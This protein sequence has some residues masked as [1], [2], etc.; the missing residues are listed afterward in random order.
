MT[1]VKINKTE[2]FVGVG[3]LVVYLGL[4]IAFLSSDSLVARMLMGLGI[5][6]TLCRSF[7]GFAGSVNRAYGTG[8]TKLMRSMAIMFLI[9]A[10]GVSALLYADPTAYSLSIYPINI[11][12]AIGATMFGTGMAF[13]TCCAS[14]VLTDLVETPIKSAIILLFFC[15]GVMIGFPLQKSQ[16]W[17]TDTIIGGEVYENGIFLPELFRFDGYNGY[18]GA[19]ILTAVFA[20]IVIS[21]SYVYENKRRRLGTYKEVPSEKMQDETT[22]ETINDKDTDYKVFSAKT[23]NRLFVKPWSLSTGAVAMSIIFIYMMA[24]T[25]SGWGVT[26]ALGR[27]ALGALSVFGVSPQALSD[28]SL[29]LI[30]SFNKPFF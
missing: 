19:I 29:E 13:A 24:R 23:F 28:F 1:T 21:L 2:F 22:I 18:L 15:I 3:I 9:T 25:G 11:G 20:F 26:T 8:S 10:I 16:S 6:Y 5:G 27:W 14:G 17:V 4:G 30:D 12:L 7:Y